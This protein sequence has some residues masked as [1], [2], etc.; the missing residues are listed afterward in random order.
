MAAAKKAKRPLTTDEQ[1]LVDK[2]LAMAND[3]IQVDVFDKVGI[4]KHE[5][6]EYVRPALRGSKFEKMTKERA[7]AAAGKAKV[8][9]SA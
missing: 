5:P 3:I 6:V 8:G 9:V 4:E 7:T 1:A 2:V